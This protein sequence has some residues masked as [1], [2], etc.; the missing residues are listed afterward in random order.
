MTDDYKNI[1]KNEAVILKPRMRLIVGNTVLD[2]ITADHDSVSLRI[3]G[4]RQTVDEEDKPVFDENGKPVYEKQS[5]IYLPASG[6][7]DSENG[8]KVGR[9]MLTPWA[10]LQETELPD[11]QSPEG[12]RLDA[13]LLDAKR[14]DRSVSAEHF[15]LRRLNNGDVLFENLSG[16]G[17]MVPKETPVHALEPLVT[18]WRVTLRK[19]D[20]AVIEKGASI[21]MGSHVLTRLEDY[22]NEK[23][24]PCAQFAVSYYDK[25]E[26]KLKH[27][28]IEIPMSLMYG[29]GLDLGREA[30]EFCQTKIPSM[31]HDDT[32]SRRQ[33]RLQVARGKLY[34][35]DTDSRN[36]TTI[37]AADKKQRVEVYPGAQNEVGGLHMTKRWAETINRE[38]GNRGQDVPPL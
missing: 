1:G 36:G 6:A 37:I 14:V 34:C 24:A 3:T 16:K 19:D 21:E 5:K 8:L 35:I 26:S 29:N 30:G 18:E 32:I 22:V 13:A 15:T 20:M 33:C 17:T 11:A 7:L 4:Y 28:T 25:D 31:Q 38:H 9:M 10:D 23:G 2:V 27:E 12:R